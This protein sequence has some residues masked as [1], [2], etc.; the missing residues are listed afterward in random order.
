MD[1]W[2]DIYLIFFPVAF[3]LLVRWLRESKR[4]PGVPSFGVAC[5]V[6]GVLLL[7]LKYFE[8]PSNIYAHMLFSLAALADIALTT[9]GMLVI[10]LWGVYAWATKRRG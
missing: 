3:G 1:F 4:L 6:G 2:L 7:L 10:A 5:I 9:L 8:R